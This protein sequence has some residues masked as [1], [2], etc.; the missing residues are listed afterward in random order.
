M[1]QS[2]KSSGFIIGTFKISSKTFYNL[3]NKYLQI[4]NIRTKKEGRNV[5]YNIDDFEKIM[6]KEYGTVDRAGIK[7]REGLYQESQNIENNSNISEYKEKNTNNSTEDYK[8]KEKS[9]VSWTDLYIGQLKSNI[10]DLKQE[11]ESLKKDRESERLNGKEEVIKMGEKLDKLQED[12]NLEK[13][14]SE[15]VFFISDRYEKMFKSYNNLLHDFLSKVKSLQNGWEMSLSDIKKLLSEYIPNEQLMVN[16]GN[17][18]IKFS[19][20]ANDSYYK[21]LD[22]IDPNIVIEKSRKD[23][24]D[25]LNEERVKIENLNREEVVKL[26]KD[27]LILEKKNKYKNLLIFSL[28][29][30]IIIFLSYVTYVNLKF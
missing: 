2:Y 13:S 12:L 27:K 10:E 21:S 25:K 6:K 28:W 4:I 19:H 7:V 26:N 15:K 22:S 29:I 17:G 30:F 11:K 1:D 23:E 5:Y 3:R 14:R 16:Q 18:E 24:V 20:Y 8:V 9:E